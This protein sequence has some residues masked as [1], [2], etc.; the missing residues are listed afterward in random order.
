MIELEK[1]YLAKELP[2][3]SN[4]KSKSMID[5][6]IPKSER[7]PIL[8][9]R[10]NGDKFEITKKHPTKEGDSSK[11]HEF[12]INLTGEEFNSLSQINGKITEKI[13]YE[14]SYNGRICEIDVFQGMLKGLVLVDFEFD[15][16]EEK[17]NFE[18]PEFCL[19]DVTHEEFV[20][21]G[22]VC[23]KSYEDIE[24]ELKKFNY[25]KL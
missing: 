6:F 2:D 19:A 18:M 8:R 1:T 3:L 24:E 13:R 4:C 7:H 23:G 20:A 12:T 10:K 11:Q 17:D 21:G 22:M 9:I 5:V 16:E 14:F 25:K 15:S